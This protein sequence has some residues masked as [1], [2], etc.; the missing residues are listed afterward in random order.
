MGSR[1]TTN[2]QCHNPILKKLDR[3]L[4]NVNWN[5]VFSGLETTALWMDHDEFMPLV[6]KVWD[7]NSGVCPL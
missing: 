1:F 4:V 3:V 5:C 7:Q 6:K 2:Q